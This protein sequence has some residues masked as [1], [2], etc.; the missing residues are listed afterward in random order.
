[1]NPPKKV[2]IA[3]GKK[4]GTFYPLG[5]QLAWLLELGDYPYIDSAQAIETA[6]S[7][8]NLNRMIDENAGVDIALVGET[9]LYKNKEF[10]EKVHVLSRLY[11]S[12]WHVVARPGLNII[13]LNDLSERSDSVPFKIFIDEEGSGA[14]LTTEA[15]LTHFGVPI[16]A[17][18][19]D[20]ISANYSDAAERLLRKEIDIAVITEAMPSEEVE[21]ATSGGGHLISLVNNIP[22]NIGAPVTI[23]K[24]LY[25][26]QETEI[27][28]I[29][30]PAYLVARKDLSNEIVSS[31]LDALFEN[32]RELAL[33]HPIAVDIRTRGLEDLPSR[34]SQHEGVKIFKEREKSKLVIATGH[35]GGSYYEAGKIIQG[36]LRDQDVQSFVLQTDGSL[37]NLKHLGKPRPT[38]AIVQY[39]IALASHSYD[40]KAV[41][42]VNTPVIS[43][44]NGIA[45]DSALGWGIS[46]VSGMKRIA[47]LHEE[48]MYVFARQNGASYLT[49]HEGG[50]VCFGPRNSG[51]QILARAL[52]GESTEK[53]QR[54]V[55]LPVD[56]MAR[57]LQNGHLDIGHVVTNPHSD[58]VTKLIA[59]TSITLIPISPQIIEQIR[60]PAI[61]PLM[62][63]A[64]YS[65]DM[66]RAGS[67]STIKTNA[68][69][70]VN[71]EVSDGVVETIAA[72]VIAGKDLFLGSIVLSKESKLK[73]FVGASSSLPLHEAAERFYKENN[74]LL[75]LEGFD[76][77]LFTWRLVAT[78]VA[79]LTIGSI[80]IRIRAQ[81]VTEK[82]ERE[83]IGVQLESAAQ[84][85]VRELSRIRAASYKALDLHWW[86]GKSLPTS[87]WL[88]IDEIIDKRITIARRL[89][90][91]ALA[92]DIRCIAQSQNENQA[93]LQ[94][95]Y[96]LIRKK[97]L[98]FFEENELDRDQYTF[99]IGMIPD[100][101]TMDPI[102]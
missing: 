53:L 61:Q 29:G 2:T 4:D 84:D 64:Q 70:V 50:R 26:N 58:V 24:F 1:M 88:F 66:D 46:H 77:M 65:A 72:A 20:T 82:F 91:R 67:I 23:P 14:R 100:T 96:T 97:I 40:S 27:I 13:S 16:S 45:L 99:L 86:T 89:L 12:V 7:I 101:F 60:G 62:V 94:K 31:V 78:L 15:L 83:V 92:K 57:Q 47:T 3:T 43:D 11:T 25:K 9:K 33:A 34:L 74:Y 8:D 71:E 35:A 75:S 49:T 87:K 69:L 55:Y 76:W 10:L 56:Q 38:I 85:S 41:Y 44:Y 18:E 37:E 42:K 30:D 36:L 80:G 32:A 73:F 59:D 102:W 6:G 63:S 68:V 81:R 93:E 39:D 21:M 52:F 95:Q 19:I 48:A 51:T 28:T 79:L 5:A 98:K 17:L 22:R 54:A 90:T